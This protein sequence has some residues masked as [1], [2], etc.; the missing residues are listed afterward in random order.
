MG[1]DSWGDENYGNDGGDDRRDDRDQ[2]RG[3]P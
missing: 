1:G 2:G 3:K